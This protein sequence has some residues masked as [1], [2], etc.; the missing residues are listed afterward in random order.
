M[1]K[2]QH[3]IESS[4][5]FFD[6]EKGRLHKLHL[7]GAK[8]FQKIKNKITLTEKEISEIISKYAKEL[9]QELESIWKPTE[10]EIKAELSDMQKKKDNLLKREENLKKIFLSHQASDIFNSRK[11]L[12]ETLPKKSMGTLYCDIMKTKFVSAYKLEKHNI[13][14]IIG[15][16]NAVPN[17]ELV[18]SYQSDFP[19]VMNIVHCDNNMTFITCPT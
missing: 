13:R 4:L 7:D 15:D 9:V 8:N 5:E 16:L 2:V 6:N 3:K 18:K 10:N 19:N 1:K 11:L 17:L 12:D 14:T